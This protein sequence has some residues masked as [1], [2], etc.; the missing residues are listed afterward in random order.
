MPDFNSSY[1]AINAIIVLHKNCVLKFKIYEFNYAV[2][3]KK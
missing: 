1:F 3:L 2:S